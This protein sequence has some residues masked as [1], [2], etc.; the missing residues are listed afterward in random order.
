MLKKLIVAKHILKFSVFY[1][2]RKLIAAPI[3]APYWNLSWTSYIQFT[4]YL[5]NIGF[6][7]ILPFALRFPEWF[8]AL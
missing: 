4:P 3:T 7:V 8:L 6:N 2:I 5:Y 1:G